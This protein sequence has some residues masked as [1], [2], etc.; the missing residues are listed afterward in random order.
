MLIIEG[1]GVIIHGYEHFLK[2]A[3][4]HLSYIERNAKRKNNKISQTLGDRNYPVE[5]DHAL[6]VSIFSAL[7]VEAILNYY[8]EIKML[9]FT[10]SADKNFIF[11]G[12]LITEDKNWYPIRK[13]VKIVNK[14]NPKIKLNYNKDGFKDLFDYRNEWVHFSG[15][16]SEGDT[17]N[18]KNGRV[19]KE[20]QRSVKHKPITVLEIG[21]AKQHFKYA[22]K[23]IKKIEES[24]I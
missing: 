6:V 12:K 4:R 19:I 15:I 23:I 9:K 8:I 1:G 5:I 16:L 13:R 11:L 22:E 14:L 20:F 18:L 3:K 21:T 2:I 17:F 24:T 7:A 10:N